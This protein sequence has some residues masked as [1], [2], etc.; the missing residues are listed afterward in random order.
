VVW[1]MGW[2]VPSDWSG[3]PVVEAFGLQADQ[4]PVP[5]ADPY[6]CGI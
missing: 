2:T 5:T 1:A 4:V 6:R 3:R